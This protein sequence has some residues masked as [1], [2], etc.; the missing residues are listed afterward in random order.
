MDRTNKRG[1]GT[2]NECI[3]VITLRMTVKAET[4]IEAIR[5]ALQSLPD[6]VTEVHLQDV[7]FPV[8]EEREQ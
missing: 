7:K 5:T 2:M 8:D 1:E 4:Q 3:L 6:T